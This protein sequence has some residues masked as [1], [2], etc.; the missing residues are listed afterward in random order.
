MN[1]EDGGAVEQGVFHGK[2]VEMMTRRDACGSMLGNVAKGVGGTN[3]DR[4][5]DGR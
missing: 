3:A 1:G 2:H 5:L 4:R